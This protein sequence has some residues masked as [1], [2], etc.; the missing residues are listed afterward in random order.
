M[1][2]LISDYRT[3]KGSAGL[4]TEKKTKMTFEETMAE[5]EET[6][7]LLEN[8]LVIIGVSSTWSDFVIGVV[9]LIVIL[10]NYKRNKLGFLPR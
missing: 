6:V 5:L 2:S 4:L 9:F 10:F 7:K 8:G 3:E 1:V